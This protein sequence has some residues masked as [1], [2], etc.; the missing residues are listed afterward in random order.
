MWPGGWSGLLALRCRL[1]WPAPKATGIRLE[2]TSVRPVFHIVVR[3]QSD[4]ISVLCARFRSQHVSAV[5]LLVR[6]VLRVFGVKTDPDSQ[7]LAG[8]DWS[9]TSLQA[10][11]PGGAAFAAD[12]RTPR[13]AVAAQWRWC[14]CEARSVVP[15]WWDESQVTSGS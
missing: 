10:L 7:I 5:R 1:T 14:G 15:S 9:V 12:P 3:Q 6:G 4:R 2:P 13:T 8:R 11:P